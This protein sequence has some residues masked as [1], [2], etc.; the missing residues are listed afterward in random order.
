MQVLKGRSE[1]AKAALLQEAAHPDLNLGGVPHQLVTRP[2]GPQVGGHLVG[3]QIF[4][5]QRVH[6]GRR[7]LLDVGSQVAQAVAVH[8]VAEADLRLH[9]V[10]LGHGHVAHVVPE[11]GHLHLLAV[12]P[13][14]GDPRPGAK[15]GLHFRVFPV[16]DDHLAVEAQAADHEPVL[17][18]AM[19]R[20]VEVHEVHVNGGPGDVLV[21]L[22]VEVGHRLLQGLQPRD[23]VLGRGEGMHPGDH[24]G[25]VRRGVGRQAY[26]VDLFRRGQHRL[27]DDAGGDGGGAVQRAGDGLRVL[28]NLLQH[29]RAIE[30]LAADQ[31]PDFVFAEINHGL[32]SF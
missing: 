30:R 10:A 18:V 13:A 21:E 19:R 6:V 2:A 14:A 3:V 20:L 25:A 12:G 17:A 27:I 29:L 8:L 32:T 7:G 22:G 4:G 31:E 11:A 1:G 28:G 5:D 23:P 9:L 16:A 24:A 26:I 15:L